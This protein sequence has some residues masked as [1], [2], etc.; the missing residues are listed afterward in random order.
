MADT[1]VFTRSYNSFAGCDIKA[2]F[3][4][5]VIGS[6]QGISWSITREKAP[7]YTMGSADPRAFARNK[8]GIGGSM[9]FIQFDSHALLKEMRDAWFWS[10]KDDLRPDSSGSLVA[11]AGSL[12]TPGS[13]VFEQET[14]LANIS[15]PFG[16][17]E[18][19]RPW[20]VDQLP[21]FDITLSAVNEYGAAAYMRILGVEI[22]NEGSGSSIDDIVLESQM[23]YVARSIAPWRPVPNTQGY[24]GFDAGSGIGGISF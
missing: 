8:R 20:Y 21:P 18:K 22:M 24:A 9:I 10:D 12:R 16:D 19:Y 23:S 1:S 3:G 13:T 2:T 14:A 11:G 15:D 6:L 4:P 17:Q 5:K 7:I